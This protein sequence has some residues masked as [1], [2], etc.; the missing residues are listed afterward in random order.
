MAITK[1]RLEKLRALKQELETLEKR[2][3]TMPSF[4]EVGDTAGD[5]RT[6]TKRIIKLYGVSNDRYKELGEIIEKK[7][8]KLAEEIIELERFLDNVEDSNMRDILRMYY[9]EGM[10]FEEVGD[11]K[12]YSPS[13][14]FYKIKDFFNENSKNSKL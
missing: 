14:I 2:Y 6:G 8:K 5:Y 10:T 3:L 13:S 4:E 9:A 1:A 11:I 12:G 7:S